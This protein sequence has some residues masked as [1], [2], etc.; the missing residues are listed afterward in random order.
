ML[1]IVKYISELGMKTSIYSNGYA[2]TRNMVEKLALCNIEGVQI[3][4]DGYNEETNAVVRGKGAFER[5]LKAVDLLIKNNIYVK[6]AVT[7]PFEIL[8]VHQKEYISFAKDLLSKYG[9]DVFEINYSYFLMP[10]REIDNAM[11]NA[12]KKDYYNLVH[13]VATAVYGDVSEDAFVMNVSNCISDSCGFGSLNVLANGDFYFCDRIPDV[14]KAGNIRYLKFENIHKSM[15]IAEQAGKIDNFKPCCD[16]ELKYICGGGCR[17]EYFRQ[18]TTNSN[19]SD[20]DFK[21]IKHRDCSKKDKEKYYDLMIKTNER[22]Y[23]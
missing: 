15:K 13:L 19:F 21:K 9:S 12:T 10:G 1:E 16:C 6:I 18:F 3:S 5:S 22:F 17:A 11:I 8:N 14:A 23:C 20:I 4:I 2:L 7:A